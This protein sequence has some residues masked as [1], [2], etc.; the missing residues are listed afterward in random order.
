MYIYTYMNF[1]KRTIKCVTDEEKETR[2]KLFSFSITFIL[3]IQ[4]RGCTHSS[5]NHLLRNGRELR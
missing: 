4:Q 5:R 1:V 3:E 2:R